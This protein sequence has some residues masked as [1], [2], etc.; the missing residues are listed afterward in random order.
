MASQTVKFS[1]DDQAL[2]QLESKSSTL[3][4]RDLLKEQTS[5]P[6]VVVATAVSSQSNVSTG[7]AT[8]V[9]SK[10]NVST[11]VA[12]AVASKTKVST[13]VGKGVAS[14]INVCSGVATA[15]GAGSNVNTVT[16]KRKS[17]DDAGY[18]LLQ[19]HPQHQKRFKRLPGVSCVMM[20]VDDD[21]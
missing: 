7:V 3:I 20:D 4:L 17:T 13:G 5:P 6:P 19:L 14:K 16:G 15:V 8:A 10:S 9:S 18:A 12:T 1:L 21:E 11:G 2:T